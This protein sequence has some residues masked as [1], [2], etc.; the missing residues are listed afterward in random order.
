MRKFLRLLMLVLMVAYGTASWGGSEKFRSGWNSVDDYTIESPVIDQDD[1]NTSTHF[2]IISESKLTATGKGTSDYWHIYED[3][4]FT[5]QSKNGEKI[6]HIFF[7]FNSKR[8]GG[9][10]GATHGGERWSCDSEGTFQKIDKVTGTSRYSNGKWDCPSSGGLTEVKFHAAG[11]RCDILWIKVFFSDPNGST[12]SRTLQFTGDE[13]FTDKTTAGLSASGYNS[14]YWTSD[15]GDPRTAT[16]RTSGTFSTSIDCSYTARAVGYYTETPHDDDSDVSSS[17]NSTL[18]LYDMTTKHYRKYYNS[19]TI[20]SG[21]YAT[22]CYD[23]YSWYVP[24]GVTAAYAYTTTATKKSDAPCYLTVSKT[25]NTGDII[26]AGVAV[27]L[28]GTAGATPTFYNPDMNAAGTKPDKNVLL[29]NGSGSTLSAS[30]YNDSN[31]NFYYL[32]QEYQN[33]PWGFFWGAAKGAAVDLKAHMAYFSLPG[34]QAAKGFI[35]QM[36]D[37]DSTTGIVAIPVYGDSSTPG[38]LDSSAPMYNAAGQRVGASYKGI[39]I[40]NGRKFVKR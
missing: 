39:V 12:G 13:L 2:R 3:K 6:V 26:P 14:V 31:Y 23:T 18:T 17:D 36:P 7:S 16:N 22:F 4:H 5:V 20:G 34:A 9:I 33:G 25:Y 8:D 32:M 15:G 40:Q 35:M 1:S 27:V 29:G 30:K 10:F 38:G 11:E 28:K 24:D 19:T 37:D 21:G